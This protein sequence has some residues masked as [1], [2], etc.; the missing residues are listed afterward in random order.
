MP[1]Q[2]LLDESEIIKV[3][4]TGLKIKQNRLFGLIRVGNKSSE[5]VER[6][7]LQREEK[8]N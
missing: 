6:A 2:F 1:I 8:L 3:Y 7:A 5:H 4:Y